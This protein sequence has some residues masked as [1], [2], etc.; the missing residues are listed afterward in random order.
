MCRGDN[1]KN[2]AERETGIMEA[3]QHYVQDAAEAYAVYVMQRT[4]E[5]DGLAATRTASTLERAYQDYLRERR[6][7]DREVRSGKFGGYL[8]AVDYQ[9]PKFVRRLAAKFPDSSLDFEDVEK[10]SRNRNL[11]ADFHIHGPSASPIPVSL[12]NYLNSVGRP[13]VCS[14]TFLSFA[15]N[16]LFPEADGVGKWINPATNERFTN[17][18]PSK[19]DKALIDNGWSKLLTSFRELDELTRTMREQFLSDE[20]EYLNEEVF[21][22]ARKR[23]GNEGIRIAREILEHAPNEVVRARVLKMAGLDGVEQHFLFDSKL[24][25][26]SITSQRF[27]KLLG[28]VQRADLSFNQAGQSLRF[29]FRTD[30]I[31]VLTIDVPFTINKNGAWISNGYD[32]VRWHEKEQRYLATGQRRPKKS[33]EIATSINTYVNLERTGIFSPEALDAGIPLSLT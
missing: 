25:V 31:G 3:N 8:T 7:S 10:D 22:E 19:R 13:Q 1:D 16:M 27:S 26:D 20:F 11:K 15:V 21:D 28:D 29:D 4:S 33:R 2:T 6:L 24:S 32:G 23:V 17:R 18:S 12:K 14:G 5:D 30:G 9:V